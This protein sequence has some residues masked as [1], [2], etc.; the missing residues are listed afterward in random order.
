MILG[1]LAAIAAPR[2][3]G[4]ADTAHDNG[5]RQSLSVIREG[6]RQ[7]RG[8]TPGQVPGRRTARKR[9]SRTISKRTSRRGVSDLPCRPGEEQSRA[10]DGR[11][12]PISAGISGTESTH[13]WVYKYE[14]GDFY[15]NC[16]DATADGAT[17]YDQF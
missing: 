1:I 14:T 12:G 7:L 15:I 13:S 9:R 17:T 4:A 8:R 5:A 3:L 6:D 2:V 16:D 10:D 11:H